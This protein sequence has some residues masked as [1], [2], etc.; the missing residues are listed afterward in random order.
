MFKAELITYHD[1]PVYSDTEEE[2]SH[3]LTECFSAEKQEFED[4][5][6]SFLRTLKGIGSPLKRVAEQI[7]D[8][9][10]VAS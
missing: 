10:K 5:C 6:I 8:G 2:Y 4:H 9:W 3:F 1:N 7:G